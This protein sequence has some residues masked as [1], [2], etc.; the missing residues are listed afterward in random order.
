VNEERLELMIELWEPE[1]AELIRIIDTCDAT[2]ERIV[3][4]RGHGIKDWYWLY[5]YF[6]FGVD[7]V[8]GSATT[9]TEVSVD[10]DRVDA[11]TVIR[12]L[13]ERL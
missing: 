13:A 8:D 3:K 2:T 5:R 11:D 4:V 9:R 6:E 10:L 1:G 7:M 12:H